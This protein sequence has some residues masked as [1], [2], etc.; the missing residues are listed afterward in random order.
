MSEDKKELVIQKYKGELPKYKFDS[1]ERSLND[2]SDDTYEKIMAIPLRKKLITILLGIFLGVLG[3]NRF[4]IND[5]KFGVIKLV[6]GAFA[7]FCALFSS[8]SLSDLII[9]A[10]IGFF[11]IIDIFWCFNKGKEVNHAE[12]MTFM[13]EEK[14][15]ESNN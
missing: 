14:A 5:I 3:V 8:R 6:L 1:F 13:R 10:F 9:I 4:Y 7:I 11:F 2:A 15:K 12:I